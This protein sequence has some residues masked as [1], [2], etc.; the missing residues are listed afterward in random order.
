MEWTAVGSSPLWWPLEAR[1][2]DRLLT[3]S[4]WLWED[5]VKA[6]GYDPMHRLRLKAALEGTPWYIGQQLKIESG[7]RFKSETTTTE[8]GVDRRVMR[9]CP[10]QSSVWVED[11]GAVSFLSLCNGLAKKIE[12]LAYDKEWVKNAVQ[13]MEA[14]SDLSPLM[15]KRLETRDAVDI[16]SRFSP[17][18]ASAVLNLNKARDHFAEAVAD[19]G[20]QFNTK[21]ILCFDDGMC[22]D[23]LA[24]TMRRTVPADGSTLSTGYR[25]QKSDPVK[26]ARLVA[27]L[28]EIFPDVDVMAWDLGE[29]AKCLNFS[30]A[31]PR[32]RFSYGKAGGGKGT[33]TRLTTLAFGDDYTLCPDEALFRPSKYESAEA[34]KSQR[35]QLQHK[36]Y[37]VAHEV[38]GISEDTVK[39]WTGG[40][41]INARGMRQNSVS[42]HPVFRMLELTYNLKNNSDE[43][44][45]F[46]RDDGLERRIK[47]VRYT[48]GYEDVA[49]EEEARDKV[50]EWRA[51]GRV[52]TFPM[53]SAKNDEFMGLAPQ[54]MTR[55]IEMHQAASLPGGSWPSEPPQV[56]EWTAQMWAGT[57]ATNP[58]T[59]PIHTWYKRCACKPRDPDVSDNLDLVDTTGRS[60]CHY[61]IGADLNAKLKKR[62]LPNG[63]TLQKSV[64]GK[65]RSDAAIYAML[66]KVK[67]GDP[68]IA[69]RKKTCAFGKDNVIMGIEPRNPTP[70]DTCAAA[71]AADAASSSF[72]S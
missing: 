63:T 56:D 2:A 47:A 34:P 50:V 7:G 14:A 30:Q 6:R 40:D 8:R 35:A 44:L 55:L 52:D 61:I 25:F 51:E 11:R 70:F 23:V 54:L 27:L 72:A 33:L 24:H 22:Y 46:E 45:K 65:A 59:E 16:C 67:M 18:T 71:A 17:Q 19:N 21:K 15:L 66:E 41:R 31:D 60:C 48:N 29:R 58:L 36:L 68:P 38:K 9:F 62:I 20:F 49:N 43:D 39:S 4:A 32:V 3:P 42:F 28:M 5:V 53:W 26:Q 37:V 10:L 13:E 69:L 64:K 12:L 1:I 57:A